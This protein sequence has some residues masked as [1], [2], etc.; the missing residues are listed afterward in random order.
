MILVGSRA[1]ALRAPSA[2]FR[3]PL[4]FDWI[5]TQAEYEAWMEKNSAKVQ[6]KKIYA[7]NGKSFHKMIVEGSTNLEF[8]IIQAGTSSEILQ[9]LVEGNSE[10]LETPFG[11]VPTFDLLFTIKS[12]HKFLKN[13]PHFWKTLVDYH[14]MKKMGATVRP[15][16]QEFL[17]L[18]EKETYNYTHPKLNVS[19]DNFFKDDG[20]VYTFMIMTQFIS[21]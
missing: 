15:E 20:L 21:R 14:V 18:R 4:D 19:K 11:W 13:S 3:K 7:E 2:L 16:Y 5:C 10:S 12:S 8:E 17:S 6:P 9:K 1:L